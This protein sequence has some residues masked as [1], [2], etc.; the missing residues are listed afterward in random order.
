MRESLIA[1]MLAL[2]EG[3]KS[4]FF[5]G[6]QRKGATLTNSFG[7]HLVAETPARRIFLATSASFWA[8]CALL[9]VRN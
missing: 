7:H 2:S 6:C 9:C 4:E 3:R 1:L 8:V 5:A